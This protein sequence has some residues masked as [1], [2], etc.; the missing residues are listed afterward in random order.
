[1][2]TRQKSVSLA[3]RVFDKLED[4][5]LMG[6]YE[7]G[8]VLTE[9][10][11]VE[12]L[13]VSRT[14][15]REALRRLAD[16]RLI[17][18]TGKGSVVLGITRADVQDIQDIRLAV[19]GLAAYYAAQNISPE[20][21]QELR[22]IVELQEYYTERQDT[23]HIRQMD[24]RFHSLICSAGGHQVISDTLRPLQRKIKKFRRASLAKVRR[25]GAAA[26]EHRAIFEA[27]ASRDPELARQCAARHI[28][29]A[30]ES[31]LELK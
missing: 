19:E 1:M 16:E 17:A 15:I 12:A 10:G 13:G 31:I 5:I 29:N 26:S 8:E 18:D 14:P 22:H 20:D 28:Q 25:A 11:L 6:R 3:D 7:K 4:D 30:G 27:I 9:L 2:Y 21:L 24:D 23:E